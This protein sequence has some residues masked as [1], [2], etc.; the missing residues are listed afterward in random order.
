MDLVETYA[1]TIWGE[2]RG[3]G[4]VGMSH[5]A[6]V[7]LN[8]ATHPRWWGTDIVKVCTAPWQFSCWNE[9]DPNLRKMNAVTIA[10]PQFAV[11]T[12]IAEQA[13]AGNLLDETG[14]ADS[15]YA[16][17]MSK[18]PS[19]ASRGKKTFEDQWHIFYRLELPAPS[20]DPDAYTVAHNSRLSRVPLPDPQG[21]E[22]QHQG[23]Q[24]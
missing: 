1:K 20:G 24:V 3:C 15:Y 16:R 4:Q 23:T 14:G 22:I 8:R 13:I 6:S 21:G 12:R 18:P 2:A 17:S 11:A 5:V 19:W 10:D 7:I 9:N